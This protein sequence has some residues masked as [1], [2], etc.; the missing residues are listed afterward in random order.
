MR[1]HE[2]YNSTPRYYNYRYGIGV[3]NNRP[4]INFNKTNKKAKKEAYI[5]LETMSQDMMR[6][7]DDYGIDIFA[8]EMNSPQR[9]MT[10]KISASSKQTSG[11][12]TWSKDDNVDLSDDRK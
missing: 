3:N 8:Y 6:I 10:W 5:L 11:R 9:K 12:Y 7:M 4:M 2:N 1:Y